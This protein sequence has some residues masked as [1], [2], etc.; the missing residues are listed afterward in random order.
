MRG[1][2]PQK[3]DCPAFVALSQTPVC[4]VRVLWSNRSYPP[5]C[6]TQGGEYPRLCS[7]V[8]GAQPSSAKWRQRQ[9]WLLASP[10]EGGALEEARTPWG[11]LVLTSS[12]G[13]VYP[14]ISRPLSLSFLPVLS[15]AGVCFE[16]PTICKSSLFWSPA[17][18]QLVTLQGH[19]GPDFSCDLQN[20]K[21]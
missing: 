9:R 15:P 18:V 21:L 12:K 7:V 19:E 16:R 5:T 11:P 10:Q 4:V 1:S 2:W 8:V 13:A 17:A 3:S 14:N 6:L 20:H